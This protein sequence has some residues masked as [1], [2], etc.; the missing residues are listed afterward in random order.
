MRKDPTD[1]GLDWTT[2]REDL[3]REGLLPDG[4]VVATL[5]WRDG[6]KIGYALGTGRHDAGAELATPGSSASRI[7]CRTLPAAT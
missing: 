7:L 1:E 2:I 3:R 4:A 6:G 5:N